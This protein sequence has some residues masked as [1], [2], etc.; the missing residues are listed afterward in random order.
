MI[1]L[2][3]ELQCYEADYYI[4]S[5]S[6]IFNLNDFL[7]YSNK[8]IAIAKATK[9]SNDLEFIKEKIRKNLKIEID[10]YIEN[11]IFAFLTEENLYSE[12]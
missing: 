7:I 11:L 5:H 3:K 8:I 10:D 2:L 6:P 9:D 4:P 1:P 12:T